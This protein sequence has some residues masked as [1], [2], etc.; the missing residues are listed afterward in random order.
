[1][2]EEILPV[3]LRKNAYDVYRHIA[4]AMACTQAAS[5]RVPIDVEMKVLFAV[6]AELVAGGRRGAWISGGGGCVW[7]HRQDVTGQETRQIVL[8][9]CG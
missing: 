3:H 1:M 2:I 8:Q 7:R 4:I 5:M 9:N 6:R